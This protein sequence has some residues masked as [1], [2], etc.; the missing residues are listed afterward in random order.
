MYFV[1]DLESG[2]GRKKKKKRRRRRIKLIQASIVVVNSILQ[3][4]LV[5]FLLL[6]KTLHISRA[7][8]ERILEL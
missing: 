1:F 7:I 8:S 3:A 5:I 4:Y 6:G 2:K